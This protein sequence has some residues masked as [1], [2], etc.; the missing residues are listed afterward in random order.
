MCNGSVFF[1]ALWSFSF[2]VILYL[3]LSL[4]FNLY[5]NS[6]F[7]FR[8]FSSDSSSH[9][10][11]SKFDYLFQF[12]SYHNSFS[13]GSIVILLR[14]LLGL[15]PAGASNGEKISHIRLLF[16]SR[17]F[18]SLVKLFSLNCFWLNGFLLSVLPSPLIKLLYDCVLW[19]HWD[20]LCFAYKLIY[21]FVHYEF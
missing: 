6:W 5:V 7:F 4:D 8:S 19:L 17:K 10:T 21:F 15:R 11:V 1:I 13:G 14:R 20:L 3:S 18:S 9:L 16:G 12:S 2:Y